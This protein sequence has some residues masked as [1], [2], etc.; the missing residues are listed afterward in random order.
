MRPSPAIV[1]SAA[2]VSRCASTIVCGSVPQSKV[3]VPPPASACTNAAGVQ[4]AGVPVPTT[5]PA[6]AIVPASSSASAVETLAIRPVVVMSK[7]L[8][9]TRGKIVRY[10]VRRT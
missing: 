7:G 8:P 10:G 3:T 2:I 4:L 6:R 5:P 9:T 1:V